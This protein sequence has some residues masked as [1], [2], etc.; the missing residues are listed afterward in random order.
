MR[1]IVL[2][3]HDKRDGAP[4]GRADALSDLLRRHGFEV[5]IRQDALLG[6][7]D[8]YNCYAVRPGFAEALAARFYC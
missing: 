5:S 3:V 2:E 8:R 7:T 1:Q 6:G 4:P